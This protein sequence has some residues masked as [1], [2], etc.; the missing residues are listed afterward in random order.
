MATT[1]NSVDMGGDVLSVAGVAL[2]V[3]SPG[4]GG[5]ATTSGMTV[6]DNFNIA[7]GTTTG[8]QIATATTQK[9]G[10]Y[11][12]TP[13]VQQAAITTIATNATGTAISTAVNAV[14]NELIALG[15]IA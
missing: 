3:T 10:F 13:V 6:T 12:A 14:I 11:G 15:L 7:T 8:T 9:L 5:L 4:L 2:G 1:Y